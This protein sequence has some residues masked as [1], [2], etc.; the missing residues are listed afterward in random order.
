METPSATWRTPGASEGAPEPAR[1]RP[2]T[3][4]AGWHVEVVDQ[5]GSTNADLLAA[6]RQGAPHRSVLVAAHQSA[7]RGRLDRRWEAPPGANLL[8]SLLFR[9]PPDDVHELTQR[10]GLAAVAAARS[11]AGVEAQLKWPND[12]LVGDAK[13]AGV[14]AQADT[15][16]GHVVVGIGVNVGWSPDGG[17]RLGDGI[18]PLD[19]LHALLAAHDQL[20]TDVHPLYRSS[21]ATLGRQVRVTLP[22]RELSGRA[23]DVGRDGRLAVLDDCAIT[24]HI[25]TGDVVH[26]RLDR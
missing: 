19:V 20:P 3:W 5:T 4:P 6:A 8:V 16:L 7:G 13:L 12:V 18:H 11:I 17:A 21:L 10:V 23:I 1:T 22:D 2:D 9:D 14:L 24:H 15:G 26:L 25:D